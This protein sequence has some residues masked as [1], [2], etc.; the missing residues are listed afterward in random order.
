MHLI[1][2]FDRA[3]EQAG[4]VNEVIARGDSDDAAELLVLGD[5]RSDLAREQIAFAQDR[6]GGLVTGGFESEDGWYTSTSSNCKLHYPK[7]LQDSKSQSGRHT[8]EI[9]YFWFSGAWMLEFGIYFNGARALHAA[10]IATLLLHRVRFQGVLLRVNHDAFERVDRPKHL[11]VFVSDDVLILLGLRGFVA[12][13]AKQQ[14]LLFGRHWNPDVGGN[15]VA[16]DNLFA[17]GVVF[18]GGKAQG[19]TVGQLQHILHGPC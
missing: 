3:L 11:R 15:A 7:T 18:G 8:L 6:D 19:R 9:G 16:V 14:T 12:A 13:D 5:L 4:R 10:L 17:R 2:A 1:F